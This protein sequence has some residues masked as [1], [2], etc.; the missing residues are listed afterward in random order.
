[1]CTKG[2]LVHP[3]VNPLPAGIEYVAASKF[4]ASKLGERGA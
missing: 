1:V 3:G 4:D 2:V